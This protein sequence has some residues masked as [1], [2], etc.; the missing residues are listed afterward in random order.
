MKYDYV[1]TGFGL[2]GHMLLS[3]MAVNG[4]LK[5]KNILILE[6]EDKNSNDRTWCFWEQGN[7]KWDAVVRHSWEEAF[8]INE[9]KKIE[10]LKNQYTYK[11][12][13]GS[14][15]YKYSYD[16]FKEFNVVWRKESVLGFFEDNGNCTVTTEQEEY[17]GMVLFNSILDFETIK[18]N[19]QYPLLQQHFI[20]WFIK[21]KENS[22]DSSQA[23]FMDFSV[24]QYGNTRFMYVL[25]TSA[26]E[27]LVEYTLFSPNL[28]S[29]KEYENEI[30]TY[31]ERK[32]IVDFEIVST[33]KGNIP[34][35]TYPFWKKNTKQIL[36]IGS[37]GGWTKASTGFTFKNCDV[38]TEELLTLLKSTTTDFT[39]FMR[40]T[41]YRFYDTLF[42]DVLYQNNALG[43]SV[44]SNMFETKKPQNILKFLEEETTFQEDLQVMLSCPKWP[45]IIGLF[46]RIVKGF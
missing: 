42:V 46:K 32:G 8:F 4:L 26:T 31:L 10:C 17:Q 2:A 38:L 27:A 28:L 29:T 45:F 3:K 5:N 24:N 39:Q 7:G 34:M 16:N 21:S 15:F 6:P 41:K 9:S 23:T 1:F 30:K 43:Y 37:A 18:N 33:E 36:H 13:E 40:N 11:M 44:F 14:T 20:G 19:K 25:P 35:T 12:I 22:F